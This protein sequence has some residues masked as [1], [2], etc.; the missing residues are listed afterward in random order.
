MSVKMGHDYRERPFYTYIDV[1]SWLLDFISPKNDQ[2]C[3]FC[4]FL[5]S[6]LPSGRYEASSKLD[7]RAQIHFEP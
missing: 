6:K 7:F 5:G 1:F 4:V 2:K 3:T